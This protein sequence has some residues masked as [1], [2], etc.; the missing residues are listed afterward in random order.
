MS[1]LLHMNLGEGLSQYSEEENAVFVGQ[2]PKFRRLMNQDY[3]DLEA[4][5][6]C[7]EDII[8]GSECQPGGALLKRYE[9][10]TYPKKSFA[11]HMKRIDKVTAGEIEEKDLKK[12]EK[13]WSGTIP[14]KKTD[15]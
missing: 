4:G 15:N 9:K 1:D 14:R 2:V 3:T 10:T 7:A 6:K 12:P 5:R 11:D 8:N 13:R